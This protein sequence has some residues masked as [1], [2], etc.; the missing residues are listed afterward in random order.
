[1]ETK[2]LN[3]REIWLYARRPIF[4][5]EKDVR[6]FIAREPDGR[7]AGF[8]FY[9][10]IYRDGVVIGY[11]TNICRCDE[12]S[13]GRLAT[14]IHMAAIE[15]FRGEGKQVLNLC[16]APFVKLD[17]GAFNDDLL[18]YHFLKLTARYG[19]GIYNFDGLSFHKSK[20]R[21][22]ETPIYFASN[23]RLAVKEIYLAFAAAGIS[24]SYLST[25]GLLLKG[26]LKRS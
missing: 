3:D 1:M 4:D 13:F 10:P 26:I 19:N 2:R 12:I 23:G 24:Q 11:S 20:Y 21:G 17:Q 8:A 25:M 18:F 6:K 5:T 9:D 16:L 22:R 14:A 15:T 7:I